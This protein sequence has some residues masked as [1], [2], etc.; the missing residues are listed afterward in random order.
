MTI[1]RRHLLNAGTAVA[2]SIAMPA[3]V[4]AQGS[5]PEVTSLAFGF[6]IDPPFAPHIVAMQKGWLR[7]A[8]FTDVSTKT[9]SSGNLAGEALIG[10]QIQLW[11]P[12]N[13]PPIALAANG[14][15]VVVL[16]TNCVNWNLEKL[17]VRNDAKV[18][19]PEDLTRIKIGLLQGSTSSAFIHYLAQAYKLDETKLQLVNLPPPEQ[20]AALTSNDVQALICW[21]PWPVRALSTVACRV[22][23][24]GIRSEFAQNKGAQVQVSNNRSL[25]VAS[26]DFVRRNPNTVDTLLGVMVRAQRYVADPK[27]SA[28]VV[29]MFSQFQKQEMQMNASIWSNYVFDPTFDQAYVDDMERTAAYLLRAGRIRKAVTAQEMSYTEPLKRIDPALVKIEGKWKA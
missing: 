29:M 12:G 16:A 24:T 1:S 17:V 21:E 7:E 15:P 10:G 22:V 11:T 18:E 20:L 5:K 8:G 19:A 2:A 26:E 4:R 14:V 6:G 13:L 27:N 3:L 9:F 25:M 28:E 23:H